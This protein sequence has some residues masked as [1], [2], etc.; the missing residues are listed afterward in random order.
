M[1]GST[2]LGLML[3]LGLL[4]AVLFAVGPSTAAPAAGYAYRVVVPLVARDRPNL[5]APGTW[6]G[7]Q[8]S[9]SVTDAGATLEFSCAHATIDESLALD[10][11]GRF[12]VTGTYVRE[13]GGPI[14]EGEVPDAHPARFAGSVAGSTMTLTITLSED[15]ANIGTFVLVLGEPGHPVKCL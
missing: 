12:D 4:Q 5:V 11:E 2:K 3:V 8:V 6:G 13:H 9:M 7:G 10:S 14:R 1:H 15:G